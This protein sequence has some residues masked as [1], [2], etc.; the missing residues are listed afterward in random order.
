MR[1][2]LDDSRFVFTGPEEW[3]ALGLGTTAVFAERLVYNLKRSG[4]FD[5]GGRRFHLRRV[6]FPENPLPEWFVVDLFEHAGAA[7]AA[8]ED[9]EAS[10]ARGLRRGTFD[11]SRLRNMAARYGT[12]ATRRRIESA[13]ANAAR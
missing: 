12:K 13:I 3:N 4:T 11:R 6:A 5:L 2:F 10:L 1:A 7:A 8:P 9:L